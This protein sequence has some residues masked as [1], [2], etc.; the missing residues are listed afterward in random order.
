MGASN[1]RA[2]RREGE[3][4]TY[5]LG[6][7]THYQMHRPLTDPYI[8]DVC[9]AWRKAVN[10]QPIS[11][12]SLLLLPLNPPQPKKRKSSRLVAT[13]KSKKCSVNTGSGKRAK[14]FLRR[15]ARVIWSTA[16]RSMTVSFPP[17]LSRAWIMEWSW[18][19]LPERRRM[20]WTVTSAGR[21]GRVSSARDGE[22]GSAR[23]GRLLSSLLSTRSTWFS[24]PV[25][26]ENAERRKKK[27][28]GERRP[29]TYP[30]ASTPSNNDQ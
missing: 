12:R 21:R 19:R 6:H 27:E 2:P 25:R 4:K 13:N 29:Q 1:Q 7:H 9:Q 10:H 16:A 15:E 11:F 23:A 22:G 30:S 14:N 3:E 26:A 18:C 24:P 17:A 20:P 5:D 28:E 8:L